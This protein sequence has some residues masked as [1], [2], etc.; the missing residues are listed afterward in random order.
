MTNV[1]TG[2]FSGHLCPRLSIGLP[3]RTDSCTSMDADWPVTVSANSVLF[4]VL[5]LPVIPANS[6]QQITIINNLIKANSSV[7]T[8]VSFATI[9]TSIP[10]MATGP[11]TPDETF[12]LYVSNTQPTEI[13]Q[14]WTL[15][16][17]VMN[18][19]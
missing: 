12:V 2:L 18:A 1:Q 13:E 5:N 17:H 16:V 10:I 15:T 8:S 14:G 11:I 4:Q 3:C 6:V 9:P 19:C 7:F